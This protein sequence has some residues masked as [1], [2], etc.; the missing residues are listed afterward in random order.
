[1]PSR[2]LV[3]TL[4]VAICAAPSAGAAAAPKYRKTVT[5]QVALKVDG[6]TVVGPFASTETVTGDLLAQPAVTGAG[7]EPTS[8]SAEGPLDFGP[9][10]NSGLP[11]GCQLTTTAPTGTWKTSLTKSAEQLE[12]NWSTITAP[13]TPSIV[14]CQG[15]AAP[16]LGGA[17]V[18]PFLLLEPKQF[19]ISSQGGTQQLTG[20]LSTAKGISENIGTMTITKHEQCEPK[21]KEVNTYPPG[22]QTALSKMAGRGFEPGQ[23]YT[24]DTR[25][26]FVYEDGSIM[27]LDKGSSYRETAD[28]APQQDRSRSFKG[29]L[30]LGKVWSKVTSVFGSDR[31]FEFQCP[32]RCGGGVRGTVFWVDGGKKSASISVGKGSVWFSKL[33]PKGKLTGPKVI[34]K[35]GYTATMN[36]H[37]KISL[38]KTRPSDAFGFGA[39]SG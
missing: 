39:G 14:T 11:G 6:R 22:Q 2:R 20:K 7:G 10:E 17:Q 18:E 8:W 26:E 33:T 34:I 29:T 37:G 24:A 28:C 5:Y 38:R 21:V 30:L 15:V 36:R 23:K 35:A 3:L 16:F 32:D 25:V 4:A 19:T 31:T 1:M 12:V 13:I 9:I 27:R